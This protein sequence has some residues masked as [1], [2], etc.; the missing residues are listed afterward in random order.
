MVDHHDSI[1][2]FQEI[3]QLTPQIT[4]VA[5]QFNQSLSQINQ[6][7][8]LATQSLIKINQM[9]KELVQLA[10]GE[11]DEELI[12]LINILESQIEEINV[13]IQELDN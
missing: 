1:T 9:T 8:D 4:L 6:S 11:E 2:N 5:T 13:H 3:E 7:I 10:Q 12:Q